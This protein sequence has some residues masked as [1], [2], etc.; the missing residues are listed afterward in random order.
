MILTFVLHPL[1]NYWPF[2]GI[3]EIRKGTSI[4]TRLP[5][6]SYLKLYLATLSMYLFSVVDVCG[7]HSVLMSPEHI[8]VDVY[9]YLKVYKLRIM[10]CVQ[11]WIR[12][13]NRDIMRTVKLPCLLCHRG[14]KMSLR[15][16]M[17]PD[18]CTKLCYV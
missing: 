13:V 9:V 5:D 3:L 17:L 6:G 8:H 14:G 18:C 12:D 4:T 10:S 16:L 1:K 2:S 15:R 11:R 7:I